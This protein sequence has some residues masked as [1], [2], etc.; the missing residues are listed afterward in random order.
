MYIDAEFPEVLRTA[1][2]T[3][4]AR[5]RTPTVATLKGLPPGREGMIQTLRE[6]RQLALSAV[7]SPTQTV[8][9]IALEI[10]RPFPRQ[11]RNQAAAL[12]RWVQSS[13][14][15]VRDPDGV[16]LV[17][18]PEKT[19]EQR[20]GDCDDQSTLLAALL[21]SVGH[22]ARFMA[23]GMKG[24]PFSH[25]LV[26]TKIGPTENDWATAETIIPKPFGWFPANVTSRYILKV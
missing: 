14:Q 24:N 23:I 6:M 4:A 16:E 8:R 7:K 12:Q 5:T 18:T 25:V 2:T 17:A 1:R 21:K 19:I 15:Y 13:I 26:Q 20:Q 22:P 3:V 10:I 11:W 9:S